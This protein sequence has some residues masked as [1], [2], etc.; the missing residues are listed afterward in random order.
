MK[1]NIPTL[2]ALSQVTDVVCN[3]TSNARECKCSIPKAPTRG[4]S[5]GSARIVC[6]WSSFPLPLPQVMVMSWALENVFKYLLG[7]PGQK[8]NTHLLA[9]SMPFPQVCMVCM[10]RTLGLHTHPDWVHA[11]IQREL[12]SPRSCSLAVTHSTDPVTSSSKAG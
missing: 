7:E 4:K 8:L 12:V 10:Y 2:M 1:Y 3:W 11:S 6:P 9:R 5:R